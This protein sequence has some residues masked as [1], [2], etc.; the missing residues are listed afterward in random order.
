LGL[1]KRGIA[2]RNNSICLL[3]KAPPSR[4]APRKEVQYD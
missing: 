3:K 4:R 1:P 2:N